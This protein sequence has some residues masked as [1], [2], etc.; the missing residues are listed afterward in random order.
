MKEIRKSNFGYDTVRSKGSSSIRGKSQCS[1][2]KRKIIISLPKLK[3][4]QQKI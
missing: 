2:I 4:M 3:F 1:K